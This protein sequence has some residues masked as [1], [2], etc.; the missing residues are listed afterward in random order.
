MNWIRKKIKQINCEHKKAII[1]EEDQ[2]RYRAFLFCPEC[3]YKM[4]VTKG[5]IWVTNAFINKGKDND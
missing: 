5:H 4:V 2:K 3:K 1:I